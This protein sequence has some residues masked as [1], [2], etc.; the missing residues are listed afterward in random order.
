MTIDDLTPHQITEAARHCLRPEASL[1]ELEND[2]PRILAV[3]VRKGLSVQWV[4]ESRVKGTR[5]I[6]LSTTTPYQPARS[7]FGLPEYW[8]DRADSII[9]VWIEGEQVLRP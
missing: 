5:P 6:V 4:L 1:K 7:L 3:A 9:E 8:E 2:A